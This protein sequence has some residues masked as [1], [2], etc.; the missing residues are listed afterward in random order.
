M[1]KFPIIRC[2][3]CAQSLEMSHIKCCRLISQD[4]KYCLKWKTNLG[5]KGSGMQNSMSINDP[6]NA[7]RSTQSRERQGRERL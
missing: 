5:Y 4:T 6:D 3:K 1:H 7:D 2:I